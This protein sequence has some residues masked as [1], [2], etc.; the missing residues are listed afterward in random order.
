MESRGVS[1]WRHV[2]AAW[3]QLQEPRIVPH[4]GMAACH[5]RWAARRLLSDCDNCDSAPFGRGSLSGGGRNA[6]VRERLH[7]SCLCSDERAGNR[8]I[9]SLFGRRDAAGRGEGE[10]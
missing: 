9:Q 5:F 10:V 8:E 1:Y 7:A 3:Q 6:R 4:H 2:T